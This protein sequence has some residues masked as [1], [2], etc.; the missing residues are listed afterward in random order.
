M[1]L[2]PASLVK[3]QDDLCLALSKAQL[4]KCKDTLSLHPI[5]VEVQVLLLS[6]EVQASQP[7]RPARVLNESTSLFQSS[8]NPSGTNELY[9]PVLVVTTTLDAQNHHWNSAKKT[10]QKRLMTVL[11]AALKVNLMTL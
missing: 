7:N 10:T 4:E 9:Y 3:Y 11:T 1:T 6:K 2:S 8:N 5:A